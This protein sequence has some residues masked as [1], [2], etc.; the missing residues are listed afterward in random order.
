MRSCSVY[1]LTWYRSTNTV[2]DFPG[3]ALNATARR[4]VICCVAARS[5]CFT[6]TKVQILTRQR[7]SRACSQYRES[8][9]RTIGSR[10]VSICTLVL[11]FA[12]L[13]MRVPKETSCENASSCQYAYFYTSKLLVKQLTRVPKATSCENVSSPRYAPTAV[14]ARNLPTR[15]GP[16]VSICTF[17]LVKQVN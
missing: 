10:A 12:L 11:R 4:G 7:S 3:H 16:S 1:L 9:R 8:S 17:V 5:T 14:F 15:P 6:S 13:F 2:S